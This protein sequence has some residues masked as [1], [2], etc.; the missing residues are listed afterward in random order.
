MYFKLISGLL[1]FLLLLTHKANSQPVCDCPLL[2]GISEA[3]GNENT[4]N[5]GADKIVPLQKSGNIIC[6]A[7]AL[8]FLAYNLYNSYTGY[9]SARYYLNKAEELYKK[10]GCGDEVYIE[11]NTKWFC[12]YQYQ[13][14]YKTALEYLMKN[15]PITE[16]A[17]KHF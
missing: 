9:D 4:Q 17:K 5:F 11:L 16:K 8:E 10:S 15:L 6:E 1:I 14:N 13:G 7:L 2:P 12:F 3:L